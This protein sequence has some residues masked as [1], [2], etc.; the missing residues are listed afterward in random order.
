MKERA[1]KGGKIE[2]TL[3]LDHD[4]LKTMEEIEILLN[5]RLSKLE[6]VQLMAKTTL[7]VLRKKAA[8]CGTAQP[9]LE[10]KL[11]LTPFLVPVNFYSARFSSVARLFLGLQILLVS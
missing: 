9:A 1:V 5:K 3:L 8:K 2:A 11:T 4:L 10:G 6:L 7:E